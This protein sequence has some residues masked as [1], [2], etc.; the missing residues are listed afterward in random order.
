MILINELIAPISAPQVAGPQPPPVPVQPRLDSID[1]L[2][3]ERLHDLGSCPIWSLLNVVANEHSPG[4]RTA[5][6]LLRLRLWDRLKRLCR[7]GVAFSF[8]RNQISATEPDPARRRPAFRR[9]RRAVVGSPPMLGG[10][11]ATPSV[12]Q[13]VGRPVHQAQFQLDKVN[14]VSSDAPSSAKERE[15]EADQ[16]QFQMDKPISTPCPPPTDVEKAKSGHEPQR[17]SEAA[18]QIARLPR[19]PKR[20]SGWIG[21]VRSYR[22]MRVELPGG[23]QVFVFGVLRGWLIYSREPDGPAGD[24]DSSSTSWGVL[25]ASAVKIVKN[26]Q[27]I[28]LGRRKRGIKEQSSPLKIT[29]A[30]ANGRQPPGPGRKRGRPKL[31]GEAG[32]LHRAQHAID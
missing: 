12:Q 10:S 22:N 23:D 28:L 3:L 6:R 1:Q 30:R 2:L 7:L 26:G 21:D 31:K 14:P 5:V 13:E 19:R 17:I 16:V 24:P 29:T 20:W 27:A 15:H 18:R 25:P 32:A 8:A 4:N 11:A 9:Q